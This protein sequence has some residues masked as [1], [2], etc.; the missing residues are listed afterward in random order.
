M[1]LF[2]I[3]SPCGEVAAASGWQCTTAIGPRDPQLE[4]VYARAKD[5][6]PRAPQLERVYARAKNNKK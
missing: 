4:R 1:G 6:G 5:I 3:F 2:G